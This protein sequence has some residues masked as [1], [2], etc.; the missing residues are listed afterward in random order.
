MDAVT[1]YKH[2]TRRTQSAVK[3]LQSL[4]EEKHQGNFCVFTIRCTCSSYTAH[5]FYFSWWK[6]NHVLTEINLIKIICQLK[7]YTPLILVKHRLWPTVGSLW[8]I[9]TTMYT[10]FCLQRRGGTKIMYCHF[11]YELKKRQSMKDIQNGNLSCL[12]LLLIYFE[13]CSTEVLD[14]VFVSQTSWN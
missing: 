7:F 6:L 12:I 10:V 2:S 14:T 3:N 13:V 11:T 4:F 8:C 1:G 9:K 5:I